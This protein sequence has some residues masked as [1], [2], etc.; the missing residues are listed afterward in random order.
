M[1][2]SFDRFALINGGFGR[3]GI[4]VGVMRIG[5]G[6]FSHVRSTHVYNILL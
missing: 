5:F 2:R 3:A 1:V 4:G 6:R